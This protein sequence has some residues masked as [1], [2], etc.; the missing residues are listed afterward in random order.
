MLSFK[1]IIKTLF[2]FFLAS[3]FTEI[4]GQCPIA[5]IETKRKIFYKDVLNE[6]TQKSIK[7]GRYIISTDNGE[8]LLIEDKK[9][10][11]PS[12]IGKITITVKEIQEN[13]N[14]IQL[15]DYFDCE[16]MPNPKVFAI[17]SKLDTFDIEN[18]MPF[19]QFKTIEFLTA[20]SIVLS[21]RY[22][23]TL[24]SFKVTIIRL[25]NKID[26]YDLKGNDNLQNYIEVNVGDRIIISRFLLP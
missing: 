12:R 21:L 24:E 5:I 10:I 14:T 9:Y 13:G 19:R 11:K 16:R 8:L 20:K 25:T 18:S 4:F 7:G 17:S 15:F 1:K 3:S 2:L 26:E 6:Y 23:S 22:K